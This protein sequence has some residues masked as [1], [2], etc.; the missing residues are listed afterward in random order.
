MNT[1]VQDTFQSLSPEITN[2]DMTDCSVSLQL[3]LNPPVETSNTNT[4]TTASDWLDCG[5]S[6]HVSTTD[7]QSSSPGF[8]QWEWTLGSNSEL[9]TLEASVSHKVEVS[10]LEN[11][12]EMI[13]TLPEKSFE[14]PELSQSTTRSCSQ[15]DEVKHSCQDAYAKNRE[16]AREFKTKTLEKL[17]AKRR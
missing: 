10:S 1:T 11:V 13:S 5:L 16:K 17:R 12:A 3:G 8:P 14:E 9:K 2:N 6:Q 4:E 15:L 7:D